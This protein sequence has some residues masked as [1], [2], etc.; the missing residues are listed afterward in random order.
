MKTTVS[1][2]P[3]L[4]QQDTPNEEAKAPADKHS[5]ILLSCHQGNPFCFRLIQLEVIH[6]LSTL[7]SNS[8]VILVA[9][10]A[11]KIPVISP[12]SKW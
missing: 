6:I 4:S 12:Q 8:A 7:A 1:K 9:L 11:Y 5:T 3:S 2:Y 10:T